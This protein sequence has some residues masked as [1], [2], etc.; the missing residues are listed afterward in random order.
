MKNQRERGILVCLCV[1]PLFPV[2]SGILTSL[3]FQ[4]AQL[5]NFSLGNEQH[6]ILFNATK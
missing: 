6:L 3:W 4:P 5:V 2:C 1:K